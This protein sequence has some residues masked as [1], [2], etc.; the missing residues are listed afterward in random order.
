M[1]TVIAYQGTTLP[2][3][4][5]PVTL[6]DSRVA[7]PPGGSFHLLNQQWF[8][9]SILYVGAAGTGTV[10]GSFIDGSGTERVF[11]TG[12]AT[13]TTAVNADEVYVG[14]YKGVLFTFT[15]SVTATT[16]APNLALNDQK[17]TSKVTPNDVLI[18]NDPTPS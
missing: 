14:M 1:Q 2:V 17:P 9:W 8:Q 11:Y 18:D 13:P 12:D 15:A 3:A 5:T 4:A 6:F 16:F 7:F 10:T